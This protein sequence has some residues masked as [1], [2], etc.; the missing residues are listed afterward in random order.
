M[1]DIEYVVEIDIQRYHIQSRFYYLRG[2]SC[3][4]PHNAYLFINRYRKRILTNR[5]GLEFELK[6]YEKER[7]IDISLLTVNISGKEVK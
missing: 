7:V 6:R 5:N 4:I 2:W 3:S 1:F